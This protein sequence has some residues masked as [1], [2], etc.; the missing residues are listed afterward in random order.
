MRLSPL[1][2]LFLPVLHLGVLPSSGEVNLDSGGAG[3]TVKDPV[4]PESVEGQGQ[5][6]PCPTL[7]LAG[8]VTWGG[9]TPFLGFCFSIF[10]VN[11]LDLACF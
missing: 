11:G 7:P 10:E 2:G 8:F 1:R 9:A 4:Q 3:R 6:R 5:L